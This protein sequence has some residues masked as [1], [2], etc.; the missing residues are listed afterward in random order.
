MEADMRSDIF[1]HYQKLTFAF[2]DNQ[3]VG[4]IIVAYY[5]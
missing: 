1:G 3:K 5:E 4:A 2:Y